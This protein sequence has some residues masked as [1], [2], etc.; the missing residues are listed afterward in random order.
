MVDGV[1][2]FIKPKPDK[3][4]L[5]HRLEYL[6]RRIDNLIT[7]KHKTDKLLT[8]IRNSQTDDDIRLKELGETRPYYPFRS[9]S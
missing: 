8:E 1:K 9:L 6:D 7:L 2:Y 4:E 3:D 5:D